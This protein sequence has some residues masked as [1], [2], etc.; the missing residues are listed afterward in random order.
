M[1]KQR[2]LVLILG[3]LVVYFVWSRGGEMLGAGGTLARSGSPGQRSIVDADV[4][5]LRIAALNRKA[6]TFTPG[7]NL[8]QRISIVLPPL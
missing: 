5:A 2:I 3:V 6:D 7:R 4:E 1:T 8:F